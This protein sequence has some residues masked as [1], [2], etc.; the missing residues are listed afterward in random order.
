VFE[1]KSGDKV[2]HG[3]VLMVP[4]GAAANPNAMPQVLNINFV[5]SS[6]GV[7]TGTM[8]PYQDPGCA[9]EVQTTFVGRVSG[10]T[11]E[12]TFTTT[13]KGSAAISTGR[14]KI[15]RKKV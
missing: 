4:K 8:D 6:G 14:W 12:G 5:S 13:P 2:A 7:V 3:D 1:L 9:C 10:D 15:A 11:I